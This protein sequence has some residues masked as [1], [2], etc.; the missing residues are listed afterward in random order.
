MQSRIDDAEQDWDR[1]KPYNYL[2]TYTHIRSM[3]CHEYQ[4]QPN[5]AAEKFAKSMNIA[6]KFEGFFRNAGFPLITETK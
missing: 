2:T 3:A 5:L 4:V 6:P 1:L